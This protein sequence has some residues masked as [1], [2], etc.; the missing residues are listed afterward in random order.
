[1]VEV[2]AYLQGTNDRLR[3]GCREGTLRARA[4]ARVGIHQAF[5]TSQ[6]RSSAAGRT[7]KDRGLKASFRRLALLS[8]RLH[9]RRVVACQDF[10]GRLRKEKE[11][12]I[13]H[14]NI[15]IMQGLASCLEL[16][17]ARSSAILISTLTC[18][19][20]IVSITDQAPYSAGMSGTYPMRVSEESRSQN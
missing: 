6:M 11:P 2:G 20:L 3:S 16:R 15:R 18:V 17:L 12:Y 7:P 1:M 10:K 9:I 13:S 19:R 4:R 5:V 14:P 8:G